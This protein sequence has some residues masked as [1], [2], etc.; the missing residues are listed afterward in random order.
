MED[1]C[2]DVVVNASQLAHPT[3]SV[4]AMIEKHEAA[5]VTLLGF[6]LFSVLL[7]LLYNA[8]RR[9]VFHDADNVDTAFDA[10]GNVST[11][12][13]AVTIA[14]QLLWPGDMLQTATVAVKYGVSGAFWYSMAASINITLFPLL[15]LQFKTRAP[16]AKTY[17]QVIQARFGKVTHT[18][19]CV[20]ALLINVV[21]LT[22]LAVVGVALIQGIV[23]EASPEFCM[24]VLA[25]L[26]GSYSFI[27][28]LGSTFYVCYFNAVVVFFLLG[29]LVVN[30]FYMEHPDH[31]LLGNVDVIYQRLA[32]LPGPET[33]EEG[34][35]LTFWSVGG[36]VWACTG[37]CL[38]AS[39][40]FCDQASWQSRVAAKP[41]QGVLGF[42]L[43]TFVWFAVP[44]A[45]GTTTGLSYLALA[46][47]N[48]SMALTPGDIDAG[49]VTVYV[50][51]LVLG[52]AGSF[53][54]LIMFTMLVMSTGSSEIM[55]VASIFVYDIYQIYINPFRKDVSGSKC[56]LCGRRRK[57]AQKSNKNSSNNYSLSEETGELCKCPSVTNCQ[58]CQKDLDTKNKE[59]P[60]SQVQVFQCPHHGEYRM[61]QS[62][63]LSFK[64][65]CILAITIVFIP[66]GLLVNAAG[67]DLNWV[68]LTGSIAT[69]PC[70][71]GV[72]LS[73]MWVKASAVGL[74]VG[75]IAGLVCGISAN[76]IYASTFEGGLSQ[77]LL[78]TA[79]PYAVL[80]GCCT[81]LF[82]ALLL[83][84][85]VSL[86]THSIASKEDEDGEWTK[87]RQIKNPLHPWSQTFAEEF[88]DLPED[89]EPSYEQLSKV[90]RGATLTAII[91]SA[92]SMLLLV[93]IIPGVMASLHVLSEQQFRAW[94]TTLQVWCGLMAGLV[95]VV[96][97]V[98]ELRSVCGRIV[99]NRNSR[100]S[101]NRESSF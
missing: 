100:E 9:Y 47:H 59:S 51:Q 23:T 78:N 10:G 43:A 64:N 5:L 83:T 60:R 80:T 97:P 29:V 16:G 101:N 85:L 13:T 99:A 81:S 82:T 79:H 53:L 20:Y 19:F 50:S 61:Y 58:P 56:V 28:G 90:F 15:S 70:F 65:T 95:L 40:T 11:T 96:T 87:L 31:P 46:A 98:E 54:I 21:I 76:L 55:A 35:Y 32:C 2:K 72:V 67:L 14:S 89:T 25:T 26:C 4:M 34:S 69:I 75:S 94:F 92:C 33:N 37:I 7:A 3:G 48:S 24:L 42:L 39:I 57:G 63:L 93:I 86:C 52:R 36:I 88:P 6:S 1:Q 91:G 18:V 27:G 12:L 77:F 66:F 73:L 84:V 8:I 41:V 30:I 22:A 38:T 68:M 44:S 49:L 17:L 62:S 45:I 74:F 71:P